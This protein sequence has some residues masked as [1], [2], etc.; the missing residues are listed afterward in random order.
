MVLCLHTSDNVFFELV[1][2]LF[3]CFFC[4]CTSQ[5]AHAQSG[6]AVCGRGT[7][8]AKREG[9]GG[10]DNKKRSFKTGIEQIQRLNEEQR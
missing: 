5:W 8:G 1:T 10:N 6:E 4:P 9:G 3:C 7:S 2:S